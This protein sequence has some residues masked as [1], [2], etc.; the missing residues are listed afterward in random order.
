[1]STLFSLPV[2]IPLTS[3]A[4]LYPGAKAYFYVTG[5]TTPKTVYTDAD[6]TTP[7]SNPVVADANGQFAPIWMATDQAYRV[8]LKTAAGVTISGYPIDGVGGMPLTRSNI[9]EVFYPTTTAETLAGVTPSNHIYEPGNVLRYGA[10]GDGV[11]NDADAFNAASACLAVTN[12]HNIFIPSGR[13][14]KLSTQW[15]VSAPNGTRKM[16]VEGYGARI[17]TSG[18]ISG[19]KITGRRVTVKGLFIDHDANTSATMGIDVFGATRITIQDCRISAGVG[20][21][22]T[23]IGIHARNSDDSDDDTGSFWTSI[24]DCEFY[25]SDNTMPVG[26]QIY[27]SSNSCVIANNNFNGVVVPIRVKGK[28][29][30][31]CTPN[32]TLID[33]NALEGFTTAIDVANASTNPAEGMRV[34]N[35][36]AETGTTF[37]SWTGATQ[38]A[39]VPAV[40]SGNYVLSSVTDYIYNPGSYLYQSTDMSLY[41]TGETPEMKFTSMH[42]LRSRVYYNGTGQPFA[43]QA[44][45]EGQGFTL[46][47]NNGTKV[48]GLVLDTGDAT[49]RLDLGT[50]SVYSG[51]GSPE[52]ALTAVPGSLYLDYTNGVA[53]MKNTGSGNTGW[54]L[55]TQAP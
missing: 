16:L 41:G 13:T 6:L 3:A 55:V 7:H 17:I 8:H 42:G 19:L 35:N 48:A 1:M 46:Y 29:S 49:A 27:G 47:K 14:Y 54:K 43:A 25:S 52:S 21:P 40:L 32:A 26:V 2:Q 23:Y 5:S 28:T 12:G 51:S 37:F 15:T 22:A 10:V 9:G 39:N 18:A 30:S 20:M 33:G 31:I 50:P 36:R 4:G 45:S 53:Y 34:V 44:Y 24:S 38:E 11:T